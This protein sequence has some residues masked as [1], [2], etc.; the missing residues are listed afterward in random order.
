MGEEGASYLY[1][2]TVY[3]SVSRLERYTSCPFS[4]FAK[5]GL[6]AKERE[7]FGLKNTHMG[8]VLH[9][10]VKDLTGKIESFDDITYAKCLEE[11]TG[12]YEEI[13]NMNYIFRRNN[14]LKLL[15]QRLV[16]RAAYAFY[17]SSLQLKEGEF[18]PYR[19]E[20]SFG[21]GGE[22]P[23]V[24]I[25]S[26]N[27]TIILNG[28][29]DRIDVSEKGN[30][31]FIRIIDYKSS[32]SPF[33]LYRVYEGLDLQLPVYLYAAV[34]NFNARPAGMYYFELDKP[35]VKVNGAIEAEELEKERMKMLKLK[36]Y[37]L[38]SQSIISDADKSL[39]SKLINEHSINEMFLHLEKNIKRTC[40][41]IFRG[42]N[43]ILPVYDKIPA[44]TY[45]KYK[46]ICAFDD[47]KPGCR[48]RFINQKND[49]E[50][51]WKE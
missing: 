43:D 19:S 27:K 16:K 37:T 12:L 14:R 6:K 50:I 17:V 22:I 13:Y 20:I 33:M 23:P 29:I 51:N 46:S 15:G 35:L 21:P 25:S 47:Q 41:D 36:G 45:C 32:V 5:Y 7:I 42:K 9:E 8:I 31:K 39:K 28:R 10:M 26:S 48:Y 44:C 1:G 34:R 4:Y 24:V 49:T 38:D 18:R 3:A 40:E 11:C 30:E 2:D